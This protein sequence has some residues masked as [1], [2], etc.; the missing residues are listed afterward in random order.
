MKQ[1]LII[2]LAVVLMPCHAENSV[3]I[4]KKD[5]RKLGIA[6]AAVDSM[7]FTDSLLTT[8]R[9]TI[10]IAPEKTS[11]LWGKTINVIGDSYVNNHNE[12]ASLTW[13]AKIADKYNMK[14]NAYGING[15]GM[16][17]TEASGTPM[18]KRYTAMT[19]TADYVVVVG[20]KND[21]NKQISIVDFKTGLR[22][23]C[24]GLISKYVTKKICFFTP[25][26]VYSDDAKDPYNIKLSEYV[27]AIKEVCA[28]Y[29]IPV[30]DSSSN[31][32]IYMFNA[33]FRANYCQS[34]S[35]VSHLNEAGHLLFMNK[36]EKFLLGL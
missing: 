11:T 9:D 27:N 21:Y 12:S 31:S 5:G 17:T 8:L 3:V 2:I 22:T 13:A 1:I 33:S 7:A 34:A 32:G 28:E 25:W 23:L 15:N 20:G 10:Y 26:R 30:F 4:T 18:V 24:A 36:A 14:Y 35:D 6:L 29:S 16:V 19:S